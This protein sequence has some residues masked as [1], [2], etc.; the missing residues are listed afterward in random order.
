MKY[1]I[2]FE[3]TQYS[4]EI[5]SVGCVREDGEVFK[6]FVYVKPS[7]MSGFITRLTGITKNDIR[8]A[9]KS[10]EVFERFFYWIKHDR[11]I[12]FYCY[13]DADIGFIRTNL[14]KATNIHAIAALS[15]IGTNLIDF[16]QNVKQYFGLHKN[17]VLRKL[18]AY[19]RNVDTI[20]QSHDALEDSLFLKEVYDHMACEQ[21]NEDAFPEYKVVDMP[22][23][24][25][26]ISKRKAKFNALVEADKKDIGLI[27]YG[28]KDNNIWECGCLHTAIMRCIRKAKEKNPDIKCSDSFYKMVRK[29]IL[30]AIQNGTKYY[31]YY[32]KIKEDTQS[33]NI[34]GER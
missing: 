11:N 20:Q 19:Y 4:H 18:V 16:S 7:K 21:P 30:L 1:F 9:P 2:D 32:W 26:Q 15:I 14:E 23:N 5:I 6:S 3:A 10:D 34:E 13:G 29:D 31:R 27:R 25:E 12:E 22:A 28:N 8:N 24:N 33:S 17:I